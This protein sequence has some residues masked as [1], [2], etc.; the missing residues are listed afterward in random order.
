MGLYIFLIYWGYIMHIVPPC[1][2]EV[3]GVLQVL[4]VTTEVRFVAWCH[5]NSLAAM[6]WVL[7]GLFHLLSIL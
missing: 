4:I 1:C 6:K 3:Y 5:Y 2:F 7:W